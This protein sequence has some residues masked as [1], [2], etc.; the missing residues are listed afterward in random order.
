MSP[1]FVDTSGLL[2]LLVASDRFHSR[3]RTA[4]E[5]LRASRTRLVTSSYVLVETYAL[6]QS[7]IG[8]KAVREFRAS[9]A[10]LLHVVWVD[11]ELHE[12][13]LD[14][15]GRRRSRKLSLVDAASFAVMR[16]NRIDQ[17]FAFDR[18]FEAE[19]FEIPR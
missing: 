17:A 4:F 6:L 14:D 10:P 9:F 11:E 5:A 18:H 1:V 15:L 16:A 2:A 13:A 3:A 8:T 7:R 19:G 12:R